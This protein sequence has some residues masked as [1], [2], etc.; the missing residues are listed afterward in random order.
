MLRVGLKFQRNSKER[1]EK[2]NP[3]PRNVKQ[4]PGT[5]LDS[6]LGGKYIDGT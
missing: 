5:S 6:A 4:C 2:I 3:G 1:P